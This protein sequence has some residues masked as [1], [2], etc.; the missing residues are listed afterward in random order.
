MPSLERLLERFILGD[1]EFVVVGGYAAMIYGSTYVTQD[2]DL[3][4][5]LDSGNLQKIHSAVADLHPVHRMTPQAIPF[6][7]EQDSTR[8]VKNL[9]LGTDLGQVDLLGAVP[10]GD[11]TFAKAHSVEIDLP[12]GR[13]RVLDIPALIESKELIGRSKDFLVAAQLRAILDA[14]YPPTSSADENH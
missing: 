13:C 14:T 11:F 6:V 9:Y 4:C 7:F 2:V 3:C 12:F 8:P 10:Q 1:V 5:P